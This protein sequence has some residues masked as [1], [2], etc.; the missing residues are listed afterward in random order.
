MQQDRSKA[1]LKNKV[2]NKNGKGIKR[3]RAEMES[4]TDDQFT[5]YEEDEN[6][7]KVRRGWLNKTGAI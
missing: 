5:S 3:R 2:K 6:G 4:E 1:S 7:D